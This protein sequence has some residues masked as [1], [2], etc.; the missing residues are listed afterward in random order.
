VIGRGF[1]WIAVK[2]LNVLSLLTAGGRRARSA[3]RARG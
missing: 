1:L 3:R 2:S